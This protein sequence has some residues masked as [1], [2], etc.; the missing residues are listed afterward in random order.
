[1]IARFQ[2]TSQRLRYAQVPTVA[3]V[4]G[5]A[6]GGGCELALHC[7]QLVAALESYMGLVEIGVGLLPA[8]GGT[9]E[10]A[11]RAAQEAKGGDVLP[12]LKTYF[13]NIA[14]AQVSKS[15]EEARQLGWLRATDT[16]VLNP[17][18]VLHIAKQHAIAL[19]ESAWR[20]ALPAKFAVAG[21]SG[22]ATIKGM[23]VNM[24]AGGFISEYDYV[25]AS[26]IAD[27][28]T[29]GD[30]E[31]GTLV[32]EAWILRLEREAFIHFL[33]QGNTQARIFHMLQTGKPLRN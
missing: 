17:F 14:M 4:Q 19:A 20:P 22:A 27:V 24:Q 33:Q 3:A 15:A 8:G 11:L 1:M 30:V 31:A 16:I 6:L 18:E 7:S 12:F 21:R 25:L 28:I 2:A 13:Q 10:A 29:G 26:R 32:D 5:L 23:L 9:K